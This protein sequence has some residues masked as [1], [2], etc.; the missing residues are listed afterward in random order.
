MNSET[1]QE[2]PW[3][4][5]FW[6]WFIMFIPACGVVAG[7]TTVIIANSHPPQITQDD[8]GRFAR[9]TETTQNHEQPSTE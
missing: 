2:K 5:Q 3:F 1:T 7:I 9:I 6:P 4:K 8:I